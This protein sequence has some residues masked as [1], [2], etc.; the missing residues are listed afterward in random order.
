MAAYQQSIEKMDKFLNF[1]V[2]LDLHFLGKPSNGGIEDLSWHMTTKLHLAIDWTN[3][4]YTP[5]WTPNN[6]MAVQ[7]QNWNWQGADGT[8]S[9]L[10]S[11]HNFNINIGPPDLNLCD[12]SPVLKIPFTAGFPTDTIEV[13]GHKEDVQLFGGYLMAVVTPNTITLPKVEAL[14]GNTSNSTSSTNSSASQAQA[15]LEAHKND[16]SWLMDPQGQAAIAAIQKQAMSQVSIPAANAANPMAMGQ[17]FQSALLPWINGSSQPV[18][19]TLKFAKDE[20]NIT[21]Q[22]SVAQQQ[23]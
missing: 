9:T 10:V 17:T 11:S 22:T 23:Q 8:V 3:G 15:A 2:T 18:N 13:K 5:S 7:V 1:N 19:T 16:I 20:L 14:T 21:L 12:P 4:C 6:T